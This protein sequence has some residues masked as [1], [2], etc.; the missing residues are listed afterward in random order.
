MLQWWDKLCIPVLSH[1][2]E[3]KRLAL[4]ARNTLLDI[5]IY[6]EDDEHI[7]DAVTTSD[8][9]T[10]NLLAIWLAKSNSGAIQLDENARFIESQLRGVLI[11]F[12]RKRPKV[13]APFNLDIRMER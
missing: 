13:C 11:S 5:L 2:G 7:E 9:V 10:E 3:E 1:L 6:E 12:G 4:E 8:T